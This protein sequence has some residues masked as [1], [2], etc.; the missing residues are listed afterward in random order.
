MRG[1]R[2]E[3]VVNG[4]TLTREQVEKAMQELNSPSRPKAGQVTVINNCVW[5]WVDAE[6]LRDAAKSTT[7][8]TV[9]VEVGRGGRVFT[10]FKPDNGERLIPN[11]LQLLL[12]GAPKCSVK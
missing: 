11:A 1:Q 6:E 8:D 5:V 3:V 4:I 12:D 10:S 7:H 2:N 9:C